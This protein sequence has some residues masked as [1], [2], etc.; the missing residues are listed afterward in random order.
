[1]Q[2]KYTICTCKY[3]KSIY[4]NWIVLLVLKSTYLDKNESLSEVQCKTKYYDYINVYTCTMYMKETFSF[5]L[6]YKCV[7][8]SHN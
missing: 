1:M 4:I 6:K 5:S 3:D 8:S 7:M 2:M